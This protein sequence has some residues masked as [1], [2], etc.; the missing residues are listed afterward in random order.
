[1]LPSLEHAVVDVDAGRR[2][3][4]GGRGMLLVRG[5]SVFGG[6]LGDEAASPFVEFEGRQWYRTGDLVTEDADGTL[7]FAGRLKRF[8]KLG[9]EMVSLPA[10][11]AVLAERLAGDDEHDGPAVAV[12]AAAQDGHPEI[13]LFT[14]LDVDREAANRHVREAGLSALHNVRRVV[15]L[16]ELPVLGTGKTDYRALRERLQAEVR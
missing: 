7:T 15:R 6:Y 13:V 1:M 5:P 8:V 14:T 3:P 9:G 11:E 16:P 4:D 10:I 2:V 12:E